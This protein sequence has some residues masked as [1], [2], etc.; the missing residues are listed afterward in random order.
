MSKD[1]YLR[2]P[3]GS[4]SIINEMPSGLCHLADSMGNDRSGRFIVRMG[5]PGD[6]L[7]SSSYEASGY[8]G[9]VPHLLGFTNRKKQ[10]LA[11]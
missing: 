1:T 5:S 9:S 10:G 7:G 2:D 4:K 8:T 6:P 3:V 11:S